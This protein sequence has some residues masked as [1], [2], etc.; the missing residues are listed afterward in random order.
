MLLNARK[1]F[2]EENHDT[3][4]LLAI[5]DITERRAKER[6]VKELL[7]QRQVLLQEMRH[8][9]AN[10]LHIIAGILLINAWT[11]RPE[12]TRYI[13]KLLISESCWLGPSRRPAHHR[14]PHIISRT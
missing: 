11:V 7:Q 5:E 14:P 13:F 1:L 12:E 3:M 8:C 2:H 6:E 9:M 10:S 4:I